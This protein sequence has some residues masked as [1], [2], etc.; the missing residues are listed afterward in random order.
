MLLNLEK[1]RKGGSQVKVI[2]VIGIVIGILV[3]VFIVQNTEIVEFNF[4]FWT[5]SMSRAMIVL[6]VF[7][8]GIIIGAVLRDIGIRKKDKVKK[9]KR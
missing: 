8:T 6:L 7:I 9:E 1:I 2:F 5:I 4:L 3:V